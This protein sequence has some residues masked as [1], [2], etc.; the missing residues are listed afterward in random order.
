MDSDFFEPNFGAAS[1][2]LDA[3]QTLGAS[4]SSP[5]YCVAN[6]ASRKSRLD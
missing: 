2:L 4:R 5:I 6:E 3:A 1:T